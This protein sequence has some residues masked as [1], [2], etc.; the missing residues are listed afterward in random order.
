M[1]AGPSLYYLQ[2]FHVAAT[3]RSFTRAARLLNLS[4]PS[5]SGHV[6]ALERY[7][8][9][10][11]FEIRRRRVHLTAQGEELLSYTERIFNLVGETDRAVAAVSSVE[12]GYL[13]FAASPTIGVYL[14]PPVLEHF[15]RAY[16]SVQVEV[17][18]EVTEAVVE[19]VL[20]DQV[21]LG[22]VEAPVAHTGLDVEP[23]GKDEM[24]L[25]APPGHPWADGRAVEREDLRGVR[26]LRREAGS[27]IRSIVDAMLERAGLAAET[28][29]VLGSTEALKQAVVAGAGVAWVPRAAVAREMA[30]G[31]VA[32]VQVVGIDA[33]RT[34]FL[35]RPRGPQPP[36][37]VGA[38]LELLRSDMGA[39]RGRS[40]K[41]RVPAPGANRTR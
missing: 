19:R 3:E 26:L 37:A 24:V 17:A 9:V 1:P 10:P 32:A 13:S 11:L 36:P 21:P 20:A 31:D 18:I 15:R 29:M 41:R 22:L 35:V 40:A 6:R 38:F 12:R 2:T 39:G 34:L 33:R 28:D 23:F 8:R 16:P 25:I 27:A 30:R 4:Q 14:L 5:V 7:Y